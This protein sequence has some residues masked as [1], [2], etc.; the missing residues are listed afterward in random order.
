MNYRF[1]RAS[2]ISR[3]IA[4]KDAH[5]LTWRPFLVSHGKAQEIHLQRR[6]A[7]SNQRTKPYEDL[8]FTRRT[9]NIYVT[10]KIDGLIQTHS[11]LSI[12]EVK[13]YTGRISEELVKQAT[14]QIQ[15]YAW[16]AR[17]TIKDLGT[18]HTV[19]FINRDTGE[20]HWMPVKED[21]DI[22]VK[23]WTV[24]YEYLDNAGM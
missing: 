6:E 18:E 4:Y 21:G 24:V 20:I 12:L 11:G 15:I 22:E 13:T 17:P 2:D 9:G 19:E 10:G 23:I 7:Y 1:L 8:F 16:L 3:A 14:I 5:A